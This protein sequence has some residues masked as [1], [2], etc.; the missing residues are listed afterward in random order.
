MPFASPTKVSAG[1]YPILN[2]QQKDLNLDLLCPQKTSLSAKLRQLIHTWEE[3]QLSHYQLRIKA[4][5]PQQYVQT[6][7]I[8][9]NAQPKLK[10]I[11]NDFWQEAIDPTHQCIFHGL[12]LGQEDL[13]ALKEQQRNKLAHHKR[14]NKSFILG[15]ST[16]NSQQIATAFHHQTSCYIDWTYLALGPCFHTLS[17]N[18]AQPY[19]GSQPLKGLSEERFCQAVHTFIQQAYHYQKM[20]IPLVLIGGIS[21]QNI[22]LLIE[23]LQKAGAFSLRQ[24]KAP[25]T[26]VVAAIGAAKNKNEIMA[27][28]Q[29]LNKG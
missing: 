29:A 25:I 23:R 26:I 28:R 17:K 11:A 13:N 10:I 27:I 6:A 9:A 24:D 22:D 8:L 18:K 21:S 2:I 15:L 20:D 12:H 3:C 4:A 7:K 19:Q 1:F 5:S 16:H 14:Q